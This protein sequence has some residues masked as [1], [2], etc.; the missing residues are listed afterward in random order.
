MPVSLP[1]DPQMAAALIARAEP[2]DLETEHAAWAASLRAGLPVQFDH[3]GHRMAVPLVA[4]EQWLGIMVLADRVKG[5][6]YTREETDLLKCV[7]DQLAATLLNGRLA[8]RL[9]QTAE[10]EAFQTMSTFF[11]HDLKNAANSLGLMLRNLPVH[12]DDPEFRADALRGIG[13]T[14]DRINHLVAKLAGFRQNLR[15]EPVPADLNQLVEETLME[16]RADLATVEL[17]RSKQALP[18]I[19]LDPDGI[20]SVITNLLMNA[21]DATGSNGR[22]HV[23]TSLANGVV[24]LTVSDN[25]QGM[26]ADYVAKELFRP[27]RSTKTKGLGVGMF[28][29]RMIVEAHRGSIQVDSIPAEGTTIRVLL[30]LR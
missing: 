27:F 26:T 20:R 22:I 25:G 14:V 11:V 3:G 7:A 5:M 19:P 21:R 1:C 30:P 10:L 29:C 6:A 15:L 9:R 12:F 23:A 16:I 24:I 2:F 13:G 18:E 8:A 4:G 28:Q 17:D